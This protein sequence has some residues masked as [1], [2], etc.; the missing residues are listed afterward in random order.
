MAASTAWTR[1]PRTQTAIRGSGEAQLTLSR[2]NTFWC[3]SG[4]DDLKLILDTG[5]DVNLDAVIEQV[6]IL[7]PPDGWWLDSGRWVREGWACALTREGWAVEHPQGVQLKQRFASA[8]RCRKWVDLRVDRPGGIRGPR[9]RTSVPAARTLPD[10]RVTEEERVRA[11]QLA[12]RLGLT[13]ADFLRSAIRVVEVLHAA[14]ELSTRPT[15]CGKE[16][17]LVDRP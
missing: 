14:G 16:I 4:A 15:S 10:V 12:E 2:Q 13:F 8:D 5:D 7:H 3:L 17:V 9:L 6:D 11:M 1:S